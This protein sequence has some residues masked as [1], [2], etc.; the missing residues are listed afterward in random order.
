MQITVDA[1]YGNVAQAQAVRMNS[2][3]LAGVSGSYAIDYPG[4]STEAWISNIVASLLK[5][6]GIPCA[7]ETGAFMGHTTAWLAAALEDMGGGVLV[8]AEMDPDR[9]AAVSGVLEDMN[10]PSVKRLIHNRDALA[11]IADLPDNALGLAFLDD[12]HTKE[13]VA[14]EIEAVWPK[15]A[16]GGIVCFHDVFGVCDLQEVVKHYGGYSL[17]FPRCGPAGGLGILQVR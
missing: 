8:V 16:S 13:H 5:A 14:K 12:D 7:L 1:T 11:V 6:T 17:D 4:G 2:S 10:Y 3:V 9:A 15:M